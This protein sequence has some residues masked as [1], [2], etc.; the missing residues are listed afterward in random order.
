MVA[1][2]LGRLLA[3]ISPH[4][5]DYFVLF[6]ELTACTVRGAKLL[7][8]LSLEQDPV[9]FD[10]LF[11]DIQKAEG[12]ADGVT[13]NIFMSL[14]KSFI[15]PFDRWEIKDLAKA[16]DDMI[17]CMEDIPQR[18]KLYGPGGFTP[19]MAALG[20]IM[21]RATEKVQEAVALLADMKN[22]ERIL[23]ICQ[24]IGDIESEADRVMRAGM[25]RLF[26]DGSSARQLI[27]DKELYELF[28]EAVDRSEDAADVIHGVVL[29]RI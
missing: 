28:E 12:E 11:A 26:A 6:N 24:E 22:A 1:R 5:D 16:L 4:S 8:K 29:E 15:T 17:D 27:R 9:A 21:L 7:A 2:T 3:S 18:A 23:A 14:H 25:Q 13:R 19:E 20:Q 10:L